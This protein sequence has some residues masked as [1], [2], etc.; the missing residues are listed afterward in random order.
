[1]S[2]KLKTLAP[3]VETGEFEILE[4]NE[5]NNNYPVAIDGVIVVKGGLP[6]TDHGHELSFTPTFNDVFRSR[7]G[8]MDSVGNFNSILDNLEPGVTYYVRAYAKNESAIFTGERDTIK[9]GN[10]WVQAGRNGSNI[11]PR[12]SAV[13]FKNW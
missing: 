6:I 12:S 2:L 5:I 7:L 3:L 1:M 10:V 13:S 9:V 4:Y 8:S 11:P